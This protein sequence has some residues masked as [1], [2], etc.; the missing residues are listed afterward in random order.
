[1]IR[2]RIGKKNFVKSGSFFANVI[3][4]STHDS[5]DGD[6]IVMISLILHIVLLLWIM[7]CLCYHCLFEFEDSWAKVVDFSAIL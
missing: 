6:M 5:D 3:N 2:K 4:V 7:V 1:M